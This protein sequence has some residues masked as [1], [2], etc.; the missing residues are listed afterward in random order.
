MILFT[1]QI[2]NEEMEK[3]IKEIYD[4]L[5]DISTVGC[6]I[7][8]E[9]SLDKGK[10]LKNMINKI[11]RYKS[12][13]INFFESDNFLEIGNR[14]FVSAT[15]MAEI[16]EN[17]KNGEREEVLE[18]EFEKDRDLDELKVFCIN[19]YLQ[20]KE[21]NTING[22]TF[23]KNV[24]LCED[25]K[26]LLDLMKNLPDFNPDNEREEI[27]RL[28]EYVDL[29]INSETLSLKWIA[30]NVLFINVDYLSKLFVK[31][32][33]MRFSEYINSKRME[34]AIQLLHRKGDENIK[35][36]ANQVG[37]GNNPGYFSQVFKKYTGIAPGE[38][39]EN[40]QR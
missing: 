38:Y 27:R 4:N 18:K 8:F 32:E 13:F 24:Y 35:D 5:K 40:R 29:N 26:S 16:L 2:N 23:F 36:I 30:Q 1:E 3:I 22:M 9:T 28:K 10:I 21:K 14:F 19:V 39:M 11:S 7:T 34:L 20:M 17:S 31:E 15:S 33:R 25:R 37:F 12:I 6:E